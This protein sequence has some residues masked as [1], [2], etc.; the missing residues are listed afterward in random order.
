MPLAAR[1][2]RRRRTSGPLVACASGCAA[3]GIEPVEAGTVAEAL[4]QAAKG[5][6][7]AILDYRLPDG[8]GL[9]V[10]KRL[11]QI[12]PD[13]PVI[14][15][16]AHKDV[17]VIVDAMKAGAS[18]YVTKPF[19]VERRRAPALA[20]D[21]VHG[22]YRELRRLKEELARPFS[23]DSMIGDSEPMQQVKALAAKVAQSPASTVLITGE[24]GTGKDLLAKVIHY[25]SSRAARP[26][27]NITCSALPETLLES[28]L[29]GHE[30]GAFT[31]ARQQKQGLFEQADRG[32]G[33]PRR[34][35]RDGR[36]RSRPSCFGFWRRR[37]SAGSAASSDIKVDVRVIAA[38]NRDL[39]QQV[40]DGKFREDLYYR[41]NV[42][43]H[44]DAAAAR[45]RRRRGAAGRPLHHA[46]SAGNSASRSAA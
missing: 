35:R 8:D 5:V 37:R 41:L 6:D 4:E 30:R 13:L 38:T 33:L 18:D 1:P 26:F 7:A 32:H 19:D 20:C 31:D 14:M 23:F 15:L 21:R 10:L 39:E 43:A 28:E 44:R 2:R 34:D 40:R 24:S 9:S 42:L 36:R 29:F 46:S 12:D 27:M 17:D 11:R 16:T 25:G 3:D 22:S 45:A